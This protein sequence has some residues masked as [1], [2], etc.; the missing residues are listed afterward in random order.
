MKS[1]KVG[2]MPV[3]TPK[4]NPSGQT[5]HFHCERLALNEVRRRAEKSKG[6][7]C[8]QLAG[9]KRSELACIAK[10]RVPES[11][12]RSPLSATE[13][14]STNLSTLGPPHRKGHRP[15]SNTMAIGVSGPPRR[16]AEIRTLGT[17]SLL[18]EQA[19]QCSG[20]PT[21]RPGAKPFHY[22]APDR[23]GLSRVD[24]NS[25]SVAFAQAR[26]GDAG[27]QRSPRSWKVF[28]RSAATDIAHGCLEAASE[29]CSTPDTGPCREPT[30]PI[31]LAHL[32]V[33]RNLG[34]GSSRF[35]ADRAPIRGGQKTHAAIGLEQ[36]PWCQ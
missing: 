14:S 18:D 33:S 21:A 26:P 23:L 3:P 25:C 10:H 22:I 6:L 12:D 2:Q 31:P 17:A 19:R 5:R 13:R 1:L 16:L 35:R 20:T 24:V 15:A 8:H 27:N 28:A 36:R 34:L 9:N 32:S 30:L 11:A 29:L 7:E 4:P